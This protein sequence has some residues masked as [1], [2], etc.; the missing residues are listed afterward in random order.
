MNTYTSTS[1]HVLSWWKYPFIL[2]LLAIPH[3]GNN[4]RCQTVNWQNTVIST[5]CEF[6]GT[7]CDTM[8]C[9]TYGESL[10]VSCARISNQNNEP[11]YHRFIVRCMNSNKYFISDILPAETVV[12]ITS[13]NR[14]SYLIH[15][16]RMSDSLCFF[17]GT[18]VI[19]RDL[20]PEIGLPAEHDTVTVGF[21]GRMNIQTMLRDSDAVVYPV[22]LDPFSPPGYPEPQT[23]WHPHTQITEI[24][25]TATLEKLWVEDGLHTEGVKNENAEDT[26]PLYKDNETYY[27]PSFSIVNAK[28][29]LIGTVTGNPLQTCLVIINNYLYHSNNP[30][31]YYIFIP[32][33]TQEFL[34]DIKGTDGRI[35]IS[36]RIYKDINTPFRYDYM[37]GVRYKDIV[38]NND[39]FINHLHIYSY[40]G[41]DWYWMCFPMMD[42][43]Y[44]HICRLK[45]YGA[46]SSNPESMRNDDFCLVYS[47]ASLT[48]EYGDIHGITHI[49]HINRDMDVDMAFVLGSP[50][51]N[52]GGKYPI[53]DVVFLSGFD[54]NRIAIS[55]RPSFHLKIIDLID[56]G[57]GGRPAL[58]HPIFDKSSRLRYY[59]KTTNSMDVF[60]PGNA[61]LFGSI[62][63]ADKVLKLSTQQRS[64]INGMASDITC[65]NT[66]KI[67][68]T[69]QIVIDHMAVDWGMKLICE[70]KTA[71]SNIP[72]LAVKR[73]IANTCKKT[74]DK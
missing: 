72:A 59:G 36:S 63:D 12:T 31:N 70:S 19:A 54:R 66:S 27:D 1:H 74:I 41:E 22:V 30:S 42:D 14:V 55:Y 65:S 61:F 25:E 18:K 35:I 37:H 62:N 24:E 28:A 4:A 16:M 29:Y 69:E 47:G 7:K 52:P 51:N 58:S 44:G 23:E 17:C 73:D 57:H 38:T 21:I 45:N 11:Q 10:V 5:E 60:I 39:D 33:S 2:F 46:Y 20:P 56:W 43:E 15:D 13:I 53:S 8:I 6:S 50:N 49:I 40:L 32:D 48:G 71:W 34:R 68:N 64:Y 9:R 67:I 3:I 26:V